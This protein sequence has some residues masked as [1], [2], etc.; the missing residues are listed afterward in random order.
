MRHRYFHLDPELV[1]ALLAGMELLRLWNQLV[2]ATG[3]DVEEAM[4]WMRQLQEQ[5]YIDPS[6]D[7]EAFF[8]SL[9]R[10]GLI[11]PD[12]EGGAV[13][14]GPGE[15]RLRQS[16][17]E[18]LFEGMKKGGPGYHPVPASGEGIER[19][20]ETR[21][22]EFGDDLHHLDAPRSLQ[23]ALRRTH[24]DLQL[25]E[26]DLQI[27]ETEHL[28]ACASVVAIDVSHSMIL[29]GEDR[30]TPAK[31]VALALTELITTRY[32][33]DHLSVILFGDRA[34]QVPLADLPY[35]EA[36]PFHTN[37]REALQLARG[38][39]ARQKQPNKQ[40][41][42]ITDGKPSAITEGGR[43]YKNPFGLDLR[44]VNA[45]LEEA[46]VCRRQKVVITTFML[47]TDSTL[48][49]FVDKLTRINRGRAYYASP[50]N[51]GEFLLADYIKNRRSRVR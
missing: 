26:E 8:A 22:F 3:G 48:T 2:L 49:D 40:I 9:E 29:Y 39:L 10:E 12:G 18:E 23:N 43:V 42:L 21:P 33:K 5:G 51:L 41:I 7:L 20:P 44:I 16:A 45:T 30:I 14:T 17:F 27:H 28:T 6:V 31:K 35:V 15:R 25:A 32:P 36:G 19:Q 4:D 34:E 24:G 50:Y 46:D 13:L 1:R 47:A 37:T 11:Q 38:L